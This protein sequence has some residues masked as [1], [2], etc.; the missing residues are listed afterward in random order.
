MKKLLLIALIVVMLFS[1]TALYANIERP[2]SSR[3]LED[4]GLLRTSELNT[5]TPNRNTVYAISEDWEAGSDGWTIANGSETNQWH[6][7]TSAGSAGGVGSFAMYIS[8]TNGA[9][10]TWNENQP[11]FTHFY[12]DFTIPAEALNIRMS[13][14]TKVVGDAFWFWLYAGLDIYIAPTTYTPVAGVD[15]YD[16]LEDF[17]LGTLLDIH[18]W[19]TITMEG[20]GTE[21]LAG[22]EWRLIFSWFNIDGSENNGIP[23]AIDNII[24]A[25]DLPTPEPFPALL[26][27]PAN[28]AIFV[29]TFAALNWKANVGSAPT[30][31]KVRIGT[32]S[33]SLTETNLGN[34]T[35]WTPSPALLPDTKYY[36]QIVPYNAHGD[37]TAPCPIWSF[38]TSPAGTE[39]AQIGD[40]NAT[41]RTTSIPFDFWWYTSLVQTIY[42]ESEINV[43]GALTHIEYK[44]HGTGNIPTDRSDVRIFMA[45]TDNTEFTSS[46]AAG[47]IPYSEFTLVFDGSLN[48]SQQG[49]QDVMITLDT[50]FVYTGGNL[51]IMTHKL[52]NGADYGSGNNWV[53]HVPGGNRT[54]R[55]SADDATFNPAV[56]YP[57]AARTELVPA[58]RLFFST[59]GVGILEGIVT[60]DSDGSPLS[61]VQISLQGT[62]RRTTT[63]NDGMYQLRFV[64]PGN[65]TIVA[66]KLMYEINDTH[67]VEILA[68]ETATQNIV[69]K[70]I[71][72]DLAAISLVG[73][74]YPV[75]NSA[76]VY[77]FRIRNDGFATQTAGSYT[78]KLMKYVDGD[79]DEMLDS[80]T[81]VLIA[82]T[83]DEDF[84]FI[85]NPTTVGAAVIYAIIDFAADVNETNDKSNTISV[86]VQPAGTA[87]EVI[88]NNVDFVTAFTHPI[89]Y[90][91]ET[92]LSQTIYLE[93]EIFPRGAITKL[94]YTFTR[95]ADDFPPGNIPVRFYL[96]TTD[97]E[98][99][100][101]VNDWVPYNDFELV[102]EGVL[103]VN[104]AGTNPITIDF[105]TPFI[106]EGG[107]LVIMAYKPFF[108][109]W[110][111][112]D[113]VWRHTEIGENRTLRFHSMNPGLNPA[114]S[115]PTAS[116][117][118]HLVPNVKMFF[119][120]TGGTLSGTVT[121]NSE[122]LADVLV[123]IDDTA[124][125]VLTDADGKYTFKFVTPGEVAIT[126][127]KHKF[128]DYKESGIMI[129]EG[130]TTTEDIIMTP[131]PTVTVSGTVIA[132]D[133]GVGLADC[134]ITFEGYEDYAGITTNA[135]G[136]FTITG[137]YT[138]N[139]YRLSIRR[140][141]YTTHNDDIT[142]GTTA[143]TIPE[144]TLNERAFPVSKVV[145]TITGDDVTITW[146]VPTEGEDVWFSHASNTNEDSMGLTAGGLYET[147]N[148]FTPAHLEAFG[149]AGATL[150]HVAYF[151]G[152]TA[153]N[154]NIKIYTGGSSLTNYGTLVHTQP[155]PPAE[156]IAGQWNI[157]ELTKEI[158]I[159]TNSE[160]WI[161]LE[162]THAAGQ[163][164]HAICA[165]PALN[166]FGNIRRF[167]GQSW[168]P[169]GINANFQIRGMAS[170]AQVGRVIAFENVSEYDENVV[171]VSDMSARGAVGKFGVE[172]TASANGVF[173]SQ[174]S[175][176]DPFV[177]TRNR[178]LNGRALE[179]YRIY[180]LTE[181]EQGNDDL[182][183]WLD[184]VNTTTYVDDQWQSVANGE[185]RYA[186]IALYTNDNYSDP[187]FSNPVDK[188][189]SAKL[190]V[191]LDT[192]D[193]QSVNGAFIRLVNNNNNPNFVYQATATGTAT[194]IPNVRFGTYTITVE[195]AGYVRYINNSVPISAD[196]A[197]YSATLLK[198]YVLL[199]EDFEST[200]FPPA[201]WMLVD[202]DGDGRNW[203]RWN[204]TAPN[205]P[206]IIS[207]VASMISR[208]WMGSAL[209]PNNWII[210]H[211]VHIPTSAN[212]S[213]RFKVQTSEEGSSAT[214]PQD[215]RDYYGIFIST[216]P[217]Q[218]NLSAFNLF[219][220]ERA[221]GPVEEK[222]LGL[223]AYAGQ[224]IYIAFRHYDS[225]DND[226]ILIDDIEV[227][228]TLN[229]SDIVVIPLVTSLGANYPNPFN[230]STMI[231]FDNAIEG[232]VRID[233]YNIRGQKVRTVINEHHQV[234]S[235]KVEWNGKD[236]TGTNVAS[237]VYFYRM[238]TPQFSGTRKMLLIK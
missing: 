125:R 133:T 179:G 25:Y 88:G 82:P 196:P 203:E 24:I 153:T 53:Y 134:I 128:L 186:V 29:S 113:N 159:P 235:F 119:N 10:Y 97:K 30:G 99:F 46:M 77:T 232:N 33:A 122:P 158:D 166:N 28:N 152:H 185:Y 131:R 8:D 115:Y 117:R 138:E 202:A 66:E 188:G 45:V 237:G 205:T 193:G 27:S 39:V 136:Q 103:P 59:A 181:G 110:H 144:I 148:R 112:S 16:D 15:I 31:Y 234:G 32:D 50:P 222:N 219:F 162:S 201:G 211:R 96:A 207:G 146:E 48:L 150:T 190:S 49:L 100:T 76:N 180:R 163:F 116:G 121:H 228:Y 173:I 95:S 13:F 93:S 175:F 168:G 145:A 54:I 224:S 137:V 187:R 70:E 126:A 155:I 221:L 227:V 213:L 135:A 164:P 60:A 206:P 102:F 204:D 18:Q 65:Y 80:A 56:S 157:F 58:T 67:T 43:G 184:D 55:T 22:H 34:V 118:V 35:T 208:S 176:A 5:I 130:D 229:D 51:V 111:S 238:T 167:T 37:A 57:N 225:A 154:F 165:S 52:N 230:P 47:W 210:T 123:S 191:V 84:T 142:V 231:M 236:D 94:E 92:N 218:S 195:L 192:D 3:R 217:V 141:G 23:A 189:I 170:G 75:Q 120:T 63:N 1:M 106:Y 83:E 143:L 214:P 127:T 14:D 199:F 26:V 104:V 160:L 182:W 86:E 42:L 12:R 223:N 233:V 74:L 109:D 64:T 17:Y 98:S 85:W 132:S 198:S 212:I 216:D 215:W 11:S 161:T 139:I 40:P 6:R 178:S 209:N 38:T 68:N 21:L 169:M 226:Y 36:W 78:V 69:L 91:W 87:V 79:D 129:V 200:T 61:G 7:G 171:T 156:M 194:E 140:A 220:R 108:D 19:Q 149:V 147:A 71:D 4:R 105:E 81:G 73:P 44:F 9:T 89:N 151:G 41:T 107:N 183:D 174:N 2:E 20:D 172:T 62:N 72:D 114:V 197:S 90:N 101:S 177:S 124:R